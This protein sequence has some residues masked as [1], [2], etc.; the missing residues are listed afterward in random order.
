M[1]ITE[2][3][4]KKAYQTHLYRRKGTFGDTKRNVVLRSDSIDYS[5]I[6]RAFNTRTF[7]F[8]P[9]EI[10]FVPKNTG[11][12]RLVF[13]MS[14][15]DFLVQKAALNVF[16]KEYPHLLSD[17]AYAYR[18]QYGPSRMVKKIYKR[19]K[20]ETVNYMLHMDTKNFSNNVDLNV[21]NELIEKYIEDREFKEL[22]KNFISC[23]R[24]KESDKKIF[25]PDH[26]LYNGGPLSCF[27]LN[28]YFIEFDSFAAM[29]ANGWYYRFG[30]DS[31]VF[32]NNYQN[33]VEIYEDYKHFLSNKL[34]MMVHDLADNG[35]TSIV[36]LADERYFQFYDYSFNKYEICIREVVLRKLLDHIKIIIQDAEDLASAIE[37]INYFFCGNN[38]YKEYKE[39]CYFLCFSICSRVSQFRYI[40]RKIEELLLDR[41]G[42]SR[43]LRKL[44]SQ[45]LTSLKNFYFYIKK[46]QRGYAY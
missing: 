25:S 21:L 42:K 8:K 22:L 23:D 2:E 17:F 5:G 41:F 26:G 24:L 7:I 15:E 46:I 6:A 14:L 35:K 4:L 45:N 44:I 18:K 20:R 27:L 37:Q 28:L 34:N 36:S 16:E 31:F 10:A 39:D 43:E 13:V 33:L 11:G 12:N 29:R 40:D 19:M 38:S 30:D 9:V 1:R 3:D 32:G